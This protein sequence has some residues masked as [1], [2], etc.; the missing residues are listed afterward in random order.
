MYHS[1]LALLLVAIIL[2]STEAFMGGRCAQLPSR[3]LQMSSTEGEQD[4]RYQALV[5]RIKQD[6]SFN[7][8]LNPEDRAIIMANAPDKLR[9]I[10]NNIK[11]LTG[12]IMH[13]TKGI[14]SVPDI[15]EVLKKLDDPVKRALS[16]PKSSFFRSPQLSDVSEKE[17]LRA[18]FIEEM[19]R[20]GKQLPPFFN[21]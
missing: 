12:T 4:P 20:D 11:R 15:N 2:A 14:N 3:V 16:S 6:P 19:K 8:L 5:D 18:K 13:P 1:L 21:N 17:S 9:S 7:A 10:D